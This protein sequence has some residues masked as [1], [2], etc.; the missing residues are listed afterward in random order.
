[1]PDPLNRRSAS[2]VIGVLRRYVCD[3]VNAHDF[4]V[5]GE[6]M[7]ED[8]TLETGGVQVKGRDGPYRSAVARQLEQFPGLVFTAHE[9]VHCG[10]RVGIRFTEHGASARHGGRAAAWPSIAIYQLR[11]GSLSRCAIEQDYFS[12]RRQL[13]TG[14][15][16]PVDPPAVAPW[17][18][19]EAVANP[20]AEA[21][22]R[23]WLA[24]GDFLR[25]A[26]VQVDD[27][28]ATG[29]VEP[30]VEGG[31]VE[32]LEMLSG[33]DRCCFHAVHWGTVADEFAAAG[34]PA[35]PVAIH[36]SGL[37]TVADGE[38]VGGNLI[39]DRWGLFRRLARE[40]AGAPRV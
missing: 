39:R 5:I 28:R 35:E 14:V 21:V 30:V 37:V 26:N 31:R 23:V 20:D 38:V 7:A 24:S 40:T 19:R 27:S 25:T 13:E 1:M 18:T 34:S 6:F 9:L 11:G 8:Y 15:P 10:D 29:G 16:A 12:R 17:D 36:M 22:V 33:G 4:S 32:V 3:Y 2:P